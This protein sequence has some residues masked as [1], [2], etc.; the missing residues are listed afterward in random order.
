MPEWT[1]KEHETLKDLLK[2]GFSAG[3]IAEQ[4]PGKTRNAVIS[5]IYR[6]NLKLNSGYG[7]GRKSRRVKRV[8]TPKQHSSNKP[9]SKRMTDMEDLP[10]PNLKIDRTPEELK[11]VFEANGRETVPLEDLS[12]HQC[13]WPLEVD[14]KHVGFCGAPRGAGAYC[15]FHREIAMP[16]ALKRRKPAKREAA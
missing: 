3:V 5:R 9:I 10:L 14:G 6:T 12:Q 1:D 2:K 13:K 7:T 4:M 16:T 15:E 8:L 11:A